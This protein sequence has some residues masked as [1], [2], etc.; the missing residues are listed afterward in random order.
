METEKLSLYDNTRLS[1]FRNCPRAFYWR[2]IRHLDP[3]SH[4]IALIFGSS[5]HAAMDTIWPLLTQKA[6]QRMTVADMAEAAFAGFMRKWEAEGEPGMDFFK[7][8]HP[9]SDEAK[10]YTPRNPMVALE[11]LYAYADMRQTLAGRMTLLEVE[12]PFAVPLD[13]ARP[14]L[15][16]VGRFDK[17]V[18]FEGRVYILEHKT[19]SAYGTQT[20]LRPSY[21]NS[22][23]PN[24]QVDGYLFAAHSIYGKKVKA[25][26]VD[27]ALVHKEVHDVFKFIP[28]ERQ[29]E[30][31]DA[32]LWETLYWQRQVEANSQAVPSSGNAGPYMTAFPKNT[33]SCFQFGSDCTYIDL[34]K[35]IPNPA[36]LAKDWAPEGFNILPWE[37][38]KE[39]ELGQLKLGDSP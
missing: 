22:F 38:F 28:V 9:K 8:L 39:L 36:A 14:N 31:L 5:W 17:V 21:V 32:W 2:H 11:M 35:M 23:S 13:P 7:G 3:T 12:K 27:A 24:S 30:H 29:F 20:G 18:E 6:G 34:C 25:V 15:F 1:A 37:P 10:R 26:W 19:T 33:Q 4:K 16:Y